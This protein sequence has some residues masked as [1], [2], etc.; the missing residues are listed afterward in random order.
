ML[1]Q[2]LLGGMGTFRQQGVTDPPT[3]RH[4]VARPV[5]LPVRPPT[6]GLHS[7]KPPQEIDARE[8]PSLMNIRFNRGL[9]TFRSGFQFKMSGLREP[10]L[11]LDTVFSGEDQALIALTSRSFYTLDPANPSRFILID[12]F[13]ELGVPL[14]YPQLN[15]D[16]QT[17]FMSVDA[18][19]GTISFKGANAAN[20][21]TGEVT[22]LCDATS[23][24]VW[25]ICYTSVGTNVQ[26]EMLDGAPQGPTA[27]AFFADRA[28]VCGTQDSRS[29]IVWSAPWELSEWDPGT[30]PGAGSRLL[31]DSPDWIQA[32]R[33]LGEYLIIY[34]ER[35]IFIGSRTFML[36][37]PIRFQPAPG[38][39]IG[40][41]AP[42]SIGDLGEEHIFLG[43]DNIY[44]FSLQSIIP[45]G[46]RIRE[47]MFYG[48]DGIIPKYLQN[49]NGVIAEEFSEYWLFVP[50]GKVP[51][52]DSGDEI[53]NLFSDP[54]FAEEAVNWTVITGGTSSVTWTLDG[55]FGFRQARLQRGDTDV[56]IEQGVAITVAGDYIVAFWVEVAVD[57]SI[58]IRPRAGDALTTFNLTV[59]RHRISLP[60]TYTVDTHIIRILAESTVGA[61]C[62]IDAA[63]LIRVDD[64]DANFLRPDEW[65]NSQVCYMGPNNE[66]VPFP[67]IIDRIGA[68]VPDTVWVYNYE[69]NAWSKWRI[70]VTGFGYDIVQAITTIGSLEGPISAQDWRFGEKLI[71]EFA[72]SNLIGGVD[73]VVYEMTR[74]VVDDFTGVNQLPFAGYWES[75]D[76]DLGQPYMDKTFARLIIYHEYGHP[77]T[78]VRV[79]VSTQSGVVGWQEQDV[80]IGSESTET[81]VDF[82]VTGPQ[83]RFRVEAQSP[84]YYIHGFVVKVIPRGEGNPY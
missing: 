32:A 61:E 21:Y 45:I 19:Q 51:E 27:V 4:G 24:G 73:G 49:C 5:F 84:G 54:T 37:P 17:R 15:T 3:Q 66:P 30:N 57:Q 43:W 38:Q 78:T 36:D 2:G 39:G 59:G 55:I 41:S 28:V 64:I 16:S 10:T 44:M 68:Y 67:F 77:E 71:T 70:P 56:G 29:Q 53:E 58:Q 6:R 60:V 22:L 33:R 23:P 83:V 8:S 26:A 72:P 46:D 18:G 20:P 25:A 82:F 76:F 35:S 13:N 65:G 34:K 11:W 52:Q 47:E 62:W 14:N 7:S 80:V 12:M 69:V 1:E 63:E 31:G 48:E 9:L 79:G 40:L 74:G 75:K 42:N 50:T 81:F